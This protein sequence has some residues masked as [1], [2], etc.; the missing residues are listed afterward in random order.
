MLKGSGSRTAKPL[1]PSAC[2][3]CTCTCTCTC[4]NCPRVPSH[5]DGPSCQEHNHA[6]QQARAIGLSRRTACLKTDWNVD[7]IT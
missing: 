6:I 3:T 2:P 7:I 4:T 1:S 5:F